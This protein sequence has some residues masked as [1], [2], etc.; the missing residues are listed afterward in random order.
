MNKKWNKIIK[1]FDRVLSDLIDG[2]E[3]INDDKFKNVFIKVHS[4][5]YDL[6]LDL[7]F[8]IAKENPNLNE[9]DIYNWVCENGDEP[10]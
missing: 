9:N 5:I 6:L 7:C 2:E 10:K 1:I 3:L 8:K 4:E